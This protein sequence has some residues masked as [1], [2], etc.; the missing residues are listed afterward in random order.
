MKNDS[1]SVSIIG[2]GYVGLSTAVCFADRGFRIYAVETDA[3]KCRAISSGVAPFREKG[4]DG[5]LGKALRTKRLVC[6]VDYDDAIQKSAF[7]FLT[8]GTPSRPDGS[9]D[10]EYVKSA[11]GSIG[12][13]LKS[14]DRYPHV[15]IKSTVVL[16]ST[17][18]VVK[19]ALET[20]SGKVCG[21]GFGLAS[22]P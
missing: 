8:V 4:I 14:K 10:L 5:L 15:A 17:Q 21:R 3:A 9:I 7:T 2:L 11:A 13:V 6:T 20:S 18:S 19:Q 1:V 12:K 16:G 22:N